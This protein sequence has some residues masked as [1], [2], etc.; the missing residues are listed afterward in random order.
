MLSLFHFNYFMHLRS[1]KSPSFSTED[2]EQVERNAR[3]LRRKQRAA[4]MSH[5]SDEESDGELHPRDMEQLEGQTPDPPGRNQRVINPAAAP[6]RRV[7]M[8]YGTPVT[9][10]GESSIVRPPVE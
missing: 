10:G 6:R 9:I 4:I 3:A 7:L 2:L 1:H 8:E 5:H